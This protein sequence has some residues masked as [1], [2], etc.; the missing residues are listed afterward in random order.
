MRKNIFTKSKVIGLIAFLIIAIAIPLTVN[1]SQKQQET[2]EYAFGKKTG[3]CRDLLPSQTIPATMNSR[4]DLYKW[5]ALC[6]KQCNSSAACPRNQND[7]YISPSKSNW[8]YPFEGNNNNNLDWRC[9]QLQYSGPR[10]LR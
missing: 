1:F 6:T 5:K 4:D 9:V 3:L 7:I 10:S 8:C 2:R